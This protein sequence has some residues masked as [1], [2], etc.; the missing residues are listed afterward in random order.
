MVSSASL[1]APFKFLI[2]CVVVISVAQH[3]ARPLATP[4][5]Q[6]QADVLSHKAPWSCLLYFHHYS[7][8]HHIRTTQVQMGVLAATSSQNSSDDTLVPQRAPVF[9][10][11]SEHLEAHDVGGVNHTAPRIETV[12]ETGVAFHDVHVIP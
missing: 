3:L 7:I 11:V 8:P 5:R 4:A 12:V 9:A 10:Q 6:C 1:T 2:V